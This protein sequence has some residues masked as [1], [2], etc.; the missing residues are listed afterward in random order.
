[1]LKAQQHIRSR[2]NDATFRCGTTAREAMGNLALDGIASV[3]AGG[4]PGN[5][6]PP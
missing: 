6:V 1:L 4:A 2:L 5:L 3:L